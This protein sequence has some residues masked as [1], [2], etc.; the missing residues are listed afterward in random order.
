M[1]A[2]IDRETSISIFERM[3]TMRHFE[4]AV[5]RLY[6]GERF[7]SHYHIYIGQEANGAGLLE[8]LGDEDIICTTHRNHGHIVGRGSDPGR[9]MAEILGR[10]TGF[11]GGRSGT[12]HI[13]DPS[14]GF[15]STSAI[16]GG[17]AGLATGAA[18]GLKVK[19]P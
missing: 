4:E 18:Y 7:A 5:I 1:T 2:T 9:A 17:C 8:A 13:S 10:A 16:V 12:L 3:L 14:R 19:R 15:L 11:N 6:N